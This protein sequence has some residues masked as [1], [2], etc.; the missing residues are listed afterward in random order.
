M[1]M[2]TAQHIMTTHSFKLSDP[3]YGLV[4]AGSKIY[5]GRRATE[6]ALAVRPG[7]T[8]EFS[9]NLNAEDLP[10]IRVTVTDV[11]R[12]ATFEEALD[13]L[14]MREVLMEGLT[15]HDGVEIYKKYVSLPTQ[16]KDGVVMIKIEKTID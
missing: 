7:D 5:E 9:H 13:A 4:G 6:K 3:W 10:V 1:H 8:I 15:V 11:L 14:P 12:F 2:S 16:L